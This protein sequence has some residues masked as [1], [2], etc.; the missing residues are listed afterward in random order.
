MRLWTTYKQRPPLRNAREIPP[1]NNYNLKLI[2]VQKAVKIV[3]IKD[4]K[5]PDWKQVVFT[6]VTSDS[7]LT[8]IIA[9]AEFSSA[10]AYEPVSTQSASLLEV[11]QEF[12]GYTVEKY[13]S[14]QPF[15]VGQQK[16][17]K[18]GKYHQSKVVPA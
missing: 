5:N 2:A 15:Y 13:S 4:T 17:D 1:C 18:T 3:E 12:P 10:T 8:G 11:G 7:G 6:T 16:F 14:D 9:R